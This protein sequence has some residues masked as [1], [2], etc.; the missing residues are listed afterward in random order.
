MTEVDGT[1]RVVEK[2]WRWR[3]AQFIEAQAPIMRALSKVLEE[4]Y[5]KPGVII[6]AL[7]QSG[8]MLTEGIRDVIGNIVNI[9]S[10]SIF[11]KM[12]LKH[13]DLVSD[14]TEFDSRKMKM[15]NLVLVSVL[16]GDETSIGGRVLR[17]R[18]K[19]Y[20]SFGANAGQFFLD[21]W[22]DLPSEV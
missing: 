16:E 6:E 3:P 10:P 8:E 14:D 18:A 1:A 11:N 19:R 9:T 2:K 17:E 20:S 21:N 13:C 4:A 7:N 15:K 5:P 22:W 12:D